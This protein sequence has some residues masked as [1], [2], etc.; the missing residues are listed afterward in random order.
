MWLNNLGALGSVGGGLVEF[1]S[2]YGVKG[3][4]WQGSAPSAVVEPRILE[5][6]LHLGR[7]QVR[8][9]HRARRQRRPE[10]R[11]RVRQR[12]ERNLTE[13]SVVSFTNYVPVGQ[14]VLPLSGRGVRS[15]RPGGEG[16]GGLSYFFANARVRLSTGVDVQVTYHRGRS[17]DARTI[18]DDLLTAGR[19]AEALDGYLY[20]S[21]SAGSSVEVFK[22]V[23]VFGGYGQDKNDSSDT[24]PRSGSPSGCSRRTSSTAGSI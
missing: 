5:A 24:A 11:D 7:H 21:A 14:V 9:L 13:R 10:A 23:R 18:T 4:A 6:G 2:A 3:S 20:E 19:C 17:I 1:G 22:D 15:S 8:R 16:D 12:P